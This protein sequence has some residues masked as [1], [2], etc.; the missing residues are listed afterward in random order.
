MRFDGCDELRSRSRSR[1]RE[2]KGQQ[3]RK[4]EV[5]ATVRFPPVWSGVVE[6]LVRGAVRSR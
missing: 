1:R 2:E 6:A 3:Q 4:K 5:V